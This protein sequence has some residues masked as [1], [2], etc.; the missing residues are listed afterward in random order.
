[1]LAEEDKSSIRSIKYWFK[2]I[3][4]DDNGII[5]PKEMEYFYS[6]QYKRLEY[7]NNESIVFEDILC[8]LSDIFKPQHD[9]NWTI[10][11][12][13]KNKELS[14]YFYNSLLNLNKFINI[15]QRDPFQ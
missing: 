6:E 10:Y 4:L 13:I 14:N 3:D 7:L 2:V 8:Q 1:M 15:E 12:F 11:D 9:M 5:T